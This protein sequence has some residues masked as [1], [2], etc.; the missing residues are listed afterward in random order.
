MSL[1]ENENQAAKWFFND[2]LY[3]TG[4]LDKPV[5]ATFHNCNVLAFWAA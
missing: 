5:G 4:R 2:D 1:L 3:S